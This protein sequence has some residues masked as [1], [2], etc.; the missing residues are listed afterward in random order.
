MKRLRMPPAGTGGGAQEHL[1]EGYRRCRTI[2]RRHATTY[3]WSTAL[4]PGAR[5]PHVHALYAFCRCADDI[6]D[7]PERPLEERGAALES[8]G[9]RLFSA[10]ATGGSDD[11]LIA[12]VA[13]TAS[14][15]GIDERCFRRF[16]E[17]MA[18]DLSV[19]SYD[20]FEDLMGYMDG[21]A[22]VI[23]EMMLPLLGAGDPRALG[24][25]RSLGVAFQLTNFIRDVGDDL[26]RG[27]VY[28][29]REDLERFG[30]SEALEHRRVTPGLA[31]ALAFEIERARGLYA[32][33]DAGIALLP[34]VSAR[35]V[36]VARTLYSRILERVE[37]AG[38]DVFSARARVPGTEKALVITRA[39]LGGPSPR[40]PCPS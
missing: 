31:R 38:Y 10:L 2:T 21:S 17:S 5:R 13:H 35:C 6:V 22:A 16:L 36:G 39:V 37:S 23:G 20:S 9:R 14:A 32:Q 19:S 3:F 33:A 27:R 26:L 8:L 11:P 30:A 40:R 4:L 7:D 34:A 28:L 15:L 29:P 25:A 12:A 18:M 1:A 24:P